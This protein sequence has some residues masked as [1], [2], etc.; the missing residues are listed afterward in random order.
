MN[1]QRMEK[2]VMNRE[3]FR[4]DRT[5]WISTPRIHACEIGRNLLLAFVVVFCTGHAQA[6]PVNSLTVTGSDGVAESDV[7]TT[8]SYGPVTISTT[9]QKS[10]SLA[11]SSPL[12]AYP[13][14]TADISTQATY[15]A[16][17]AASFA[18]ASTVNI[19]QFGPSANSFGSAGAL[20]NDTLTFAP[21]TGG[22]IPTAGQIQAFQNMSV[23]LMWRVDGQLDLVSSMAGE[24]NIT[25]NLVNYTVNLGTEGGTVVNI[26]QTGRI[27]PDG[28]S[29]FS[30][31]G[32]VNSPFSQFD[33]ATGSGSVTLSETLGVASAAFVVGPSPAPYDQS[34]VA[35]ANFYNT[36]QIVGIG[37]EN[38]AGNLI[39]PSDYT[40]SD[41]SGYA[42]NFLSPQSVPEPSSWIMFALAFG[43]VA[44]A[45]IRRRPSGKHHGAAE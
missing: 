14:A 27:T 13:S 19:D 7:P 45:V 34:A 44:P 22:A 29:N 31:S 8:Y 32:T 3:I 33:S 1:E 11:D 37:L 39:S 17:H 40:F 6:G 2:T 21:Q 25:T 20:A 41:A 5:I 23:V 38:A 18:T 16:L 12:Y 42:Y 43:L 4:V 36:A 15:G 28:M 24:S 35:G 10:V 30:Q 26:S 9:T